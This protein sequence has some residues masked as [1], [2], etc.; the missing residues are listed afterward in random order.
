MTEWDVYKDL[1]YTRIYHS[2]E[3]PAFLFDGRNILNH[4]QLFDIGFSVFPIGKAALK[5]F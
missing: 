4:Q 5:H 3:Q 2:M 1:D